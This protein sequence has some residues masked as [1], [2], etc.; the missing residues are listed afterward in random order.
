MKKFFPYNPDFPSHLEEYA[1][2]IRQAIRSNKHH[3]F[4][5]HLFLNFM[6]TAFGVDPVEVK[7]E[8]KVKV[9]EVRGRIDALFKSIIF[10]FKSNIE[11]ERSA[12]IIEMKKYFEAQEVPSDY[13]AVLTDGLRFEIYQYALGK[14]EN[15]SEFSLSPNDPFGTFFN[16]DKILFASKPAPPSAE[17]LSVRFGPFSAVYHKSRLIMESALDTLGDDD[18]LKVKYN[19]WNTLLSRVYGEKVGDRRLFITHTYLA[20]LIRVL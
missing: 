20:V 7:I 3:D 8:E 4:R 5:R 6:R 12:A 17:D 9:E 13:L 14:V 19:E 11:A 15:I 16:I 1:N 10:E 18:A 2:Q